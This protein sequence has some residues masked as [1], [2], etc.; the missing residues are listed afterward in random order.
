ME[1]SGKI[2]ANREGLLRQLSLVSDEL[3]QARRIQQRLNRARTYYEGE[4][5]TI[6][7]SALE[8]SRRLVHFYEVK[9]AALENIID[10][11]DMLSLRVRRILDENRK[12]F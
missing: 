12:R 11:T 2:Y 1:N 6:F 8:K 4:D 7:N 5:V 9:R 10:E 3:E